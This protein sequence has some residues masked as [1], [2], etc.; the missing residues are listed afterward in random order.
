MSH[1]AFWLELERSLLHSPLALPG[2]PPT[3]ENKTTPTTALYAKP[4]RTKTEH[5]LSNPG[6][7][8]E[9]PVYQFVFDFFLF[10]QVTCVRVNSTRFVRNWKRTWK[11]TW[12]TWLGRSSFTL[13]RIHTGTRQGPPNLLVQT[14]ETDLS[15][16]RECC[17]G[18]SVS[19]HWER[20][21]AHTPCL[22]WSLNKQGICVQKMLL[23]LQVK[24][25]LTQ[26]K[27]LIDGYDGTI[28]EPSYIIPNVLHPLMYGS[29]CQNHCL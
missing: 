23:L 27:G 25:F 20:A 11:R 26:L 7:I 14:R 19:T 22:W 10:F 5:T 15:V 17:C 28:S 6:F 16:I 29:F 4:P 12:D 2:F 3:P 1:C 18:T 13:P 24:L 21:R 9:I 8:Q